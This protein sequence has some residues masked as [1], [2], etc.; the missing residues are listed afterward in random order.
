M[1]KTI[2]VPTKQAVTDFFKILNAAESGE[3]VLALINADLENAEL[4]GKNV[5]IGL[6]KNVYEVYPE[7]DRLAVANMIYSEIK[8]GKITTVTQFDALHTQ[9]ALICAFLSADTPEE[10][11]S[12]INVDEAD[13]YYTEITSA[14]ELDTTKEL[15]AI[16]KLSEYDIDLQSS[17]LAAVENSS[18]FE[19]W[20][21]GISTDILNREL[22]DATDSYVQKLIED[23]SDVLTS[24][25]FDKYNDLEGYHGKIASA[26]LKAAPYEST[27]ELCDV[28]NEAMDNVSEEQSSSSGSSSG[29]LSGGGSGSKKNTSGGGFTAQV[30]PVTKPEPSDE[31]EPAFTDL[32][33]V[34]WAVEAI[35]DLNE[36]NIINGKEEGKF[37]PNDNITREEYVKIL[38][39]AFN[40]YDSNAVCSFGDISGNDWFA[41]Y[42]ASASKAGFVTG[43]SDLEFG[44]G[45]PVTREDAA[46]MLY[47]LIKASQ[48]GAENGDLLE[49]ADSDEISEYARDAVSALSKL[50]IVNGMSDSMFCPGE[51]C[52]R[53]QA[54]K[55]IYE[56]LRR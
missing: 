23:Y 42:V 7:I 43:I 26:I 13:N 40:V 31:K 16:K 51:F 46:T 21:E 27:K 25:D 33:S 5:H 50:G 39:L 44:V 53:A 17:I 45:I 54:A 15:S 55:M 22:S 2:Y 28:A 11:W 20:I 24:F 49:F 10:V 1:S 12:F 47:R 8:D 41:P 36:K 9:K 19:C 14:L 4:D 48:D 35:S 52:S 18:D 29:S 32:T 30:T 38:V 37:Y 6:D 34:E 3:D 56:T